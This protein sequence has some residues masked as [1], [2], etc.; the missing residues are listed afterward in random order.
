MFF[1]SNI[2]SFTIL[3][4]NYTFNYF[5]VIVYVMVGGMVTTLNVIKQ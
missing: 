5:D 4:S 3:S 1:I 2:I